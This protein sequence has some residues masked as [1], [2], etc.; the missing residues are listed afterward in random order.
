VFCAVAP[1]ICACSVTRGAWNWMAHKLSSL[2][3]WC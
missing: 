1:N 3:W 2:C